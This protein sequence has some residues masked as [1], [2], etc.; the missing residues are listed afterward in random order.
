[1]LLAAQALIPSSRAIE[2][3]LRVSHRSAFI[4]TD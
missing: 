1:M 4:E 3:A 2:L